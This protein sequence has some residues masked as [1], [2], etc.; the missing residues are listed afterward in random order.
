MYCILMANIFAGI[1]ED[2]DSWLSTFKLLMSLGTENS[3][4]SE[5]NCCDEKESCCKTKVDESEDK[6]CFRRAEEIEEV[7]RYLVPCDISFEREWI[8][9]R[10][11]A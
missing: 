2:F 9:L 7:R 5:M 11:V 8:S 10:F 3:S 6:T 4:Q 1:K